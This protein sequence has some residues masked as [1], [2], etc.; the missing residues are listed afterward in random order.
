VVPAGAARARKL[1]ASLESGRMRH[2]ENRG[3]GWVDVATATIS[4][5]KLHLDEL[6]EMLEQYEVERSSALAADA[7]REKRSL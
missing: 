2:A 3:H 6:D 4:R 1:A 7:F 5:L